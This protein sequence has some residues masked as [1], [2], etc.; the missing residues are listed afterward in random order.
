ML[1]TK[2][3]RGNSAA[4]SSDAQI[5]LRCA[6]A[7]ELEEIGNYEAAARVL[8][9]IWPGFDEDLALDGLNQITIGEVLL[10][11]GSLTGWLGSARR[12]KGAQERAKDLITRGLLCFDCLGDAE[13]IFEAQLELAWCY[14]RE[15]SFN[16]A[17]T[18]L[19][20]ALSSIESVG[21]HELKAVA[22]IRSAE[23][24]R[25]AG[26]YLA[27]LEFLNRAKHLVD[28][29]SDL[30][31]GRFHNTF[32]IVLRNLGDL[33]RRSDYVDR[34]LIEYA[35][36]S[37]YF[38]R[39]GHLRYCARV[40]NNIGFLLFKLKRFEES[41]L[42]LERARRLFKSLR[43]IGSLAQVDETRAR[44]LLAQGRNSAAERTIRRA[45][46]ALARGDER[47]LL[48]EA[49]VT[50]GSALARLGQFDQAKMAFERALKVAEEV[51]HVEQA[52]NASLALCEELGER[53]AFE[54]LREAYERADDLLGAGSSE[55]HERLR[56]CA[57]RIISGQKRP[58][59]QTV[60]VHASPQTAALLDY[61][62]RVASSDASVLILG[63]TG[64]GKEVLARLMHEWSG[65]PGRFVAIN[66]AA[67]NET[68]F[69]SQIFGH[70]KGSFTDAVSDY[71][72]AAREA[73]GGTL[74]LDE[75]GEL[76]AAVQAKLL[77]LIELGEVSAVGGGKPDRID[78]R[79][80]AATNCDLGRLVEEGRFRPDLYY[81]FA[82]QITIPPLRERSEDIR[83]LAL[84]FIADARRRYR[85]R[86][87]FSDECLAAI[88]KL[89]LRGNVR[90][91]RTLIE[92]TFIMA[93]DG[94]TI[95]PESIEI[96][97]LRMAQQIGFVDVWA[98]CSLE[99]EVHHYEAELIRRALEQSGWRV[100]RAARL[101]GITHQRL[102]FILHTRHKD[103]VAKGSASC[104]KSMNGGAARESGGVSAAPEKV[105]RA[106]AESGR[107]L[108]TGKVGS[109]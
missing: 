22:L 85:K 65:R 34:A 55:L 20:A 48:S 86:I 77:R 3:V 78:V 96:V 15:G 16:E 43:D 87:E 83:A 13:K 80:V 9:E 24:E 40:E 23:V 38:E 62:R 105:K 26:S 53:L 42:H 1:K 64:T 106:R 39:A 29:C 81:R 68:L 47:S 27:A 11:V 46:N 107:I 74:F 98:G 37:Y 10:R 95:G 33:E 61:A 36:A 5:L 31:K 101:L 45:V 50:H 8:G 104:R 60:F 25:S 91:L 102:S 41:S 28:C 21:N 97:G 103:L 108:A 57:R 100:T 69:E 90:E 59:H 49:L 58:S 44:A 67:L 54:E 66:C 6:R 76:S 84:H 63:E 72:G 2:A 18:I 56:R 7:K 70:R 35:A 79:I 32:A 73:A 92:R 75:I 89:P 88:Q 109:G 12:I 82:F 99:R 93:E 30:V 17:R 71:A 94:V 19:Q 52:V 51:G 14:W 4:G